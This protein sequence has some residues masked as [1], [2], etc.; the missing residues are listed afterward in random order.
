M[1]KVSLHFRASVLLWRYW[2]YKAWVSFKIK[3]RRS[4]IGIWWPT[5]SLLIVCGVIGTLWGVLLQKENQLEYLRYIFAGY[6]VW[7]MLAGAVEQGARELESKL[8]GGIPFFTIV[9]ERSVIVVIPFL[10]V[11]PILVLV[12]SLG[13]N[14]GLFNVLAVLI[15]MILFVFF[16]IGIISFIIGLVSLVPDMRH[17]ITAFMR[18]AFLAT[19]II[20]E[21]ERLGS[22][23]KYVWINPFYI[24]LEAVRSALLGNQDQQVLY[25]FGA[26]TL[27]VLFVGLSLL[28]IRIPKL[29]N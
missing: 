25:Y 1:I 12:C 20:W 8:G 16:L 4:K 7:M 23:Q 24:P 19:P 9:L 11:C 29:V 22:Y 6:A 28:T 3:Y 18:L 13:E 17:I 2:G 26:Y 15:S 14:I 21:V 27:A 5:I 10:M